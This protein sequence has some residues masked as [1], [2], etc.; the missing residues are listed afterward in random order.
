MVIA[1]QGSSLQAIDLKLLRSVA[2]ADRKVKYFSRK[3]P[4]S[5]LDSHFTFGHLDRIS[6]AILLN[7]CSLDF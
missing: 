4:D 5:A 3:P 2:L 6:L 7:F 1:K